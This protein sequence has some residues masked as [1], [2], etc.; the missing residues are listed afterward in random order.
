MKKIF[1]SEARENKCTK[2]LLLSKIL[3][4]EFKKIYI[5]EHIMRS[6]HLTLNVFMQIVHFILF[7]Y[8]LSNEIHIEVDVKVVFNSEFFKELPNLRFNLKRERK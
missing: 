6:D 5:D 2:L 1:D 4:I 7:Q 8:F 3:Y